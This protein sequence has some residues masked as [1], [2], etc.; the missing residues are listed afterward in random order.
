MGA[1]MI[2][3]VISAMVH[4]VPPLIP[5]PV[6]NNMPLPCAPMVTGH[7]CFGAVLY[8]ITLADF[9]LADMTDKVMDG[10]IAGFPDTYAAKVGKT[11]DAMYKACGSAFL[12]MHCSAIFP[13]CSMPFARDEAIPGMG[14]VP[15][16][17]HLCI[18]PLVMC[19]GFWITDILGS[20]TFISVPPMC[21]M[22]FFWNIW[23][24]PPQ[25]QQYDEANPFPQDCPVEEPSGLDVADDPSLYDTEPAVRASPI[26]EQARSLQ[27]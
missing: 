6:W 3:A 1:G 9:L 17:F 16:C 27:R 5:P 12:T 13:R 10:Y 19:P 26:E 8:P 22:G 25:Y 15:L 14:R 23:R 21:T 18:L 2:Q 4:I 11:S 7:N 24:I 20:C